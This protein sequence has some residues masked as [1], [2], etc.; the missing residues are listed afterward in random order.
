MTSYLGVFRHPHLNL[1]K[2]IF[3][4]NPFTRSSPVDTAWWTS[5]V[6]RNA[7]DEFNSTTP[8]GKRSSVGLHR[9]LVSPSS[10]SAPYLACLLLFPRG[11]FCLRGRLATMVNMHGRF[12]V[13][14]ARLHGSRLSAGIAQDTHILAL[15]GR[16]R[17]SLLRTLCPLNQRLTISP[18]NLAAFCVQ[19][20]SS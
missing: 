2:L 8:V 20:S 18:P 17:T 9:W 14:L 1:S 3:N 7:C 15:F 5:D 12:Y 19:R 13:A 4:R 6:R 11:F 10:R 16:G